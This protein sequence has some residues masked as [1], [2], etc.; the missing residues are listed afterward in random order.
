MFQKYDDNILKLVACASRFM[1][2]CD[3]SSEKELLAIYFGT[4]KFHDFIYKQVV[5]VQTDH[6]SII[7]IM[8]K[9]IQKIDSIDY[10]GLDLNS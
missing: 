5:D 8:K 2:D 3:S 6:K 9:P 7:S 4:Q 1:N 10:K